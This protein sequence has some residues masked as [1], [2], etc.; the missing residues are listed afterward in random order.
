MYS[1]ADSQPIGRLPAKEGRDSQPDQVVAEK[2][3]CEWIN[4]VLVPALV[5]KYLR[6]ELLKQ[7]EE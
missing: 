2:E 1:S 4:C 5:K 6:E 7:G 3:L